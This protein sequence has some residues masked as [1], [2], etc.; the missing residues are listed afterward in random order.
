MNRIRWTQPAAQDL[1]NITRYIG[2]DNP[3]AARQ[4]AKTSYEGCESL[5]NAPNRGRKGT[6]QG[7]RELLFSAL[8]YIT[9]IVSKIPLSKLCVS[10]MVRS[11]GRKG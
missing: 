8:P 2:R 1:Y 10:G 3:E 6:E 4:V 7:T 9:V 5:V 11:P